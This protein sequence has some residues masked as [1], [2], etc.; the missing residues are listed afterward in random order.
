LSRAT[1]TIAIALIAALAAISA[2][3][4]FLPDLLSPYKYEEDSRQHVWWAYRFV[5]PAL[6]P[7]DI[8]A[9]Y[10]SRFTFAPMGYQLLLRTFVPFVDAQ[11]FTDAVPFAITG[12]IVLLA[13]LLG[14]TVSGGSSLGGTVAAVLA[15][16]G[17]ILGRVQGGV[18]RSWA[19]PV[20]LF[21]L[22]GLLEKRWALFGV[23]L[24]AVVAFYP[25]LIVSV[26][27][28]GAA[29]LVIEVART[30]RLPRGFFALATLGAVALTM[31]WVA[32]RRPQPDPWGPQVTAEV[33]RTMPEFGP[34]GRLL[35]FVSSDPIEKFISNGR[36]GLDLNPP[37]KLVAILVTLALGAWFFP[38]AVPLGVWLMPAAALA[39]FIIAHITL[40]K[41]H[42]PSRHVRFVL[43]AFFMLW[44]A[45]VV[46]RALERARRMPRF[47]RLMTRI[48]R[49]GW[50]GSLAALAVVL[51]ALSATPR[52]LKE[53]REKRAPGFAEVMGFLSGLPK[54]VKIAA[55][56]RVADDIPLITK[57][58][59]I[60]C[61]ETSQSY[62]LGYY[63]I[64]KPMISAEVEA[65]YATEW[66]A[67]DQLCDRFGATVFVVDL[68]RYR[69]PID[70][71]NA[72]YEP[73]AS[74]VEG[75]IDAGEKN[76]FALENP[77]PD[78]VLFRA[79]DFIVVRLKP[80][81]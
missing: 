81:R 16:T 59:V 80:T 73:F 54:D 70:R 44:L 13:F 11:T 48:G 7:N 10:F 60:A 24:V 36:S 58:S 23:G 56:P 66:T 46:P 53:F 39:A 72:Y 22:W 61:E 38:R 55:H 71:K 50:L 68:K 52:F 19:I 76:G 1:K 8:A 47:D 62:Y 74:E 17:V 40:F 18:P 42:H 20:L 6:F 41:L 34:D 63:R 45:A 49:P 30:R 57:R 33:A 12:I 67:I 29:M 43:P 3:R 4:R 65:S 26:G 51:A 69:R 2:C 28:L 14:R 75:L 25:P 27:L 35:Y 32:Y 31:L 78:R 15:T 21:A 79:G 64:V 37:W 5:D 77:P 9:D